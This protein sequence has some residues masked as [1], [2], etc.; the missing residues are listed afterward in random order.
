[1]AF[2]DQIQAVIIT[3]L[4]DGDCE[5][6]DSV[7]SEAETGWDSLRNTYLVRDDAAGTSVAMALA[8]RFAKGAPLMA[9]MF[10]T[11]RTGKCLAPG[12]F[13]LE[14]SGKGLLSTRGYKISYDGSTGTTS[15][16]NITA[17]TPTA[18][19]FTYPKIQ[20]KEPKVTANFEYILIGTPPTE[21]TGTASVPPVVPAV[22]ASIWTSL[23]NPTYHW[24]NGWVCE[25]IGAENL[26]GVNTIW[27]IRAAYV[28]EYPFT[29]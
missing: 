12:I 17:P 5:M 26:P 10:V 24:P 19:F 6:L 29:P 13:K 20:A 11:E 9:S 25:R 27:L 28:Y 4:A 22:R 3:P 18:G 14:I 16:T 1:M 15:A 21:L 23:T 8:S 7:P 2:S